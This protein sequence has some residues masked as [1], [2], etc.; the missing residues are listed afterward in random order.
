MT[1]ANYELLQLKNKMTKV[2]F[3][4]SQV[5]FEKRILAKDVCKV[6]QRILVAFDYF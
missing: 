3:G 1:K 6:D 4:K 5:C 2:E